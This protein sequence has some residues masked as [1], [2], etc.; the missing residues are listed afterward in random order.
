MG[1]SPLTLISCPLVASDTDNTLI[2]TSTFFRRDLTELNTATA[3]LHKLLCCAMEANL[4]VD[5][6]LLSSL[7]FR[8]EFAAIIADPAQDTA[9]MRF[10]LYT[11]TF[12]ISTI[13][14]PRLVKRM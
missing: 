14:W 7:T 9:G 3:K 4:A 13:E 6:S 5:K 1:V 11:T 2:F 8:E 10:F 12:P